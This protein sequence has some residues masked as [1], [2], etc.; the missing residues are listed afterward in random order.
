MEGVSRC[1]LCG[2]VLNGEAKLRSCSLVLVQ[3]DVW[4]LSETLV[5]LAPTLV[6][7]AIHTRDNKQFH[8]LDTILL[9]CIGL[10]HHILVGW[11]K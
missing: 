10:R 3:F 11:K 9:C 7:L 2:L 5:L 8:S 4:E 1:D 6:G